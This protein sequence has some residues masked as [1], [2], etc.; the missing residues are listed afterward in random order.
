MSYK[1]R[2]RQAVEHIEQN[3]D[4]EL[5]PSKVSEAVGFSAFHFHRLFKAFTGESIKQYIRKRR[6]SRAALALRDT[7]EPIL[8]I[9]LNA[10]FESQEAFSRA[11]KKLFATTPSNFRQNG[12]RQTMFHRKALCPASLDH[13]EGGITVEP[14]YVEYEED[15]L[16][17]EGGSFG[18]EPFLE[19]TQLW[20]N[21]MP[22]ATKIRNAKR[23]YSLG[24]CC[25]QH[26]DIPLGEGDSFVY[27]A[28]LPVSK[29]EEIPE[30]MVSMKIPASTYAVFTHKGPLDKLPHTIDYI[31]GTWVPNN[32]ELHKKDAPDFELYDE[33][34]NPLSEESEFDI[35]IPVS[36]VPVAK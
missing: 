15:I 27:I 7:N 4:E 6:L 5:T 30:G 14:K 11:F 3:L 29:P 35:Y 17:G 12:M 24:V 13:L 2:I 28:G 22:R 9:S 23:G 34:F 1:S 25:R 21:F 31:W 26:P 36:R 32:A 19:I 20:K 10:G 18:D 8:S 33:R 16:V